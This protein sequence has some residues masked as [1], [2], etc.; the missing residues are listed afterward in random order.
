MS[1]G[2]E[3]LL[4]VCGLW[5]HESKAGATFYS[6]RLNRD[7]QVLIFKNEAKKDE[8]SPDLTLCLGKVEPK[9]KPAG[10]P[11]GDQAF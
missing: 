10:G 2:K 11:G 9:E 4:R 8:K 6:G 5:R 7:V 3:G 1:D